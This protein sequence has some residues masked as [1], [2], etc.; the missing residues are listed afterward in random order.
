MKQDQQSITFVITEDPIDGGFVARAHW[1]AGNRETVT[2][3][4]DREDLIR[5]IRE[6]LDASFDEA[7]QKPKLIHLHFV[8]DETL[9]LSEEEGRTDDHYPLRG[10]PYRFDDPYSPVGVE[11]WEALR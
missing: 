8:R 7:E 2:Q 10:K 1:P 4:D 9:P 6:A 5:N 11:D 3:G